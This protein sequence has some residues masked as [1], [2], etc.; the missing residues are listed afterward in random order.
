MGHRTNTSKSCSESKDEDDNYADE[1]VDL[2]VA[3]ND[4]MQDADEEDE[5]LLDEE[6]EELPDELNKVGEESADDINIPLVIDFTDKE[7]TTKYYAIRE[8]ILY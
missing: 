8:R 1:A 3:M 4:R 5:E 7:G 6:D 2:K